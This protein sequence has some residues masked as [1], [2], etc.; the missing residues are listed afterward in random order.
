MGA[1]VAKLA[2]LFD[3]ASSYIENHQN[4]VLISKLKNVY[5]NIINEYQ[6]IRVL[7]IIQYC[8]WTTFKTIVLRKIP[9]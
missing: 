8:I 2:E 9:D 7:S 3:E 5:F 1:A 6:N 4:L